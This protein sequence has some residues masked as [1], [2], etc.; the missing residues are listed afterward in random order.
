MTRHDG[1]AFD[2]LRPTKITTGYCDFPDGSV[3]IETG[4]TRVLCNCTAEDRLPPHLIGSDQGWVTAEYSMLPGATNPRGMRDIAK[5]KLNP[6]S[7][8][9]QRLIGRA[10]RSITDLKALAGFTLTVDC[11]VLQ[12]D[13]GTRTASITGACLALWLA[14]DK[15]VREGRLTKNPVKRMAAAVSI[16]LD[17]ENALLDLDYVEDSGG[18]ADFNVVMTENG[19]IIELQGTGEKRPFSRPE[20]E[21]L[22]DLGAK[23]VRELCARQREYMK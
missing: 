9:I 20:L 3:L 10:L 1:R 19:D 18:D 11:D 14:C 6:R 21:R 13:G 7:T 4:R 16:G 2:E 17:G 15:L 22:L 8:E 12:A 23:G 5:L